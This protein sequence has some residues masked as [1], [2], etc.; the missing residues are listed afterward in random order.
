MDNTVYEH[1][2]TIFVG[3][4]IFISIGYIL[5]LGV[6]F[7]FLNI[8]LTIN[9]IFRIIIFIYFGCAGSWL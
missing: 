3:T 2:C 7:L 9:N 4:Y 5:Y 8:Y 6:T 1:S